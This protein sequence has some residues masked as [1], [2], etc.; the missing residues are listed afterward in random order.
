MSY[1]EIVE[2]TKILVYLDDGNEIGGTVSG[3]TDGLLRLTG[4]AKVKEDW[5]AGISEM[6]VK[7]GQEI[8]V[9]EIKPENI[10]RWREFPETL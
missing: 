4:A 2:G 5:V 3:K 1:E 8:G 9:V 6:F 10:V 7:K